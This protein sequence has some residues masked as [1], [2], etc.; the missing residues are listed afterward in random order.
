MTIEKGLVSIITPMYKGAAFVGET[1]ETVIAQTYQNW[2]MIIVDDCSPDNGAG[3]KVVEKYASTEKRIKLI[4]NKV[5][6]GSSGA[7]NT[8]LKAA[9]GQFIAFLDSDDL[10]VP[11][12]LEKQL[13]FMKEKDA[14]IVFSSYF[15]IDENTKEEI[16]SP[17]IVPDKVTYKS[18]LMYCPIFPS[19]AI[20]D[21]KDLKKEYLFDTSHGSMRDD[22]V[23]WLDLFKEV[24]VA[25]GNK[26]KLVYYRMRKTS[27]TADKKKVIIPQ[28]NVIRKVEKRPFLECCY[29]IVCWSFIAWNKYRK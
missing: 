18:L 26:E 20:F 6:S 23:F 5:N 10:W 11:T 1:I 19:T 12:F 13:A 9:Q 3:I 25:Y 17:Y 27:V 21:R 2:E 24:P 14:K 8:A 28:W 22:Y 16:L 4:A 15:R 29:N 7:R